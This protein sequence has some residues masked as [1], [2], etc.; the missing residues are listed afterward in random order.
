MRHF[1][2]PILMIFILVLSSGVSAAPTLISFPY[3]NQTMPEINTRSGDP[4]TLDI[5]DFVSGISPDDVK[6]ITYA[7]KDGVAVIFQ[8]A[9]DPLKIAVMFMKKISGR[10]ILPVKFMFSDDKESMLYLVVNVYERNEVIFKY[11]AEKKPESL[12]VAGSFNGWNAGKNSMEDPDNDGCYTA[13]I[14]IEP[15]IHTYKFVVDGKWI[16]DPE[17]PQKKD[18]G[19]QGF[20]SVIDLGKAKSNETVPYFIPFDIKHDKKNMLVDYIFYYYDE[21]KKQPLDFKSIQ[22]LIGNSILI[23]NYSREGKKISITIPEGELKGSCLRVFAKTEKGI[24]VH[25]GYVYEM[26]ESG[27]KK[28]FDWRDAIIYFTF[29]DRFYDGNPKNGRP[30]KDS[31]LADRANW[32][33]G[34]FAGIESK[35]KE[36][37]FNKL[38]INAIWLSPVNQ[39][40]KGAWKESIPPYRWFTGYHGYWPVEAR[41]TDTRLGSIEELKNL[42]K[43][44]HDHDIKIILDFVSNHVHKNHPYVKEHPEWFGTLDLPGGKKNIRL[45]DEYPFTTWFDTFLPSFN[46]PGSQEAQKQVISDAIWWLKTTDADGFRH[47]ATKHIPHDFWKKLCRKIRKEIEIPETRS[48]YQVGETISDRET[49]MEFVGPGLL[50]GQFDY[51]LMWTLRDAFGKGTIGVDELYKAAHKSDEDYGPMAIMSPFVSSHD[52]PRFIAFCDGD[53][54]DSEINDEKEVGWKKKLKVDKKISYDKLFM[55]M[56]FVMTRPGAPMVYYGDEIGMTGAGDPDNRR[57]MRFGKS[58][59][60]QEKKM[61]TRVSNLFK[62]RRKHPALSR[63]KG[64]SLIME[65]DRIAFIRSSFNDKILCVFNRSEKAYSTKVALPEVFRNYKKAKPLLG[66]NKLKIKEGIAEIKIPPYTAEF[67]E[68]K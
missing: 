65:K 24:D 46:Y 45:F 2:I 54:P 20:N 27:R 53:L 51:P 6:S 42:V 22:A 49:I 5:R 11:K 44:A 58:I 17:N 10:R 9:K 50:T 64:I 28:A 13:S 4:L 25:E 36:G 3:H 59:N 23:K 67:Y 35:I 62:V 56:A 21:S 18:D 39:N 37:Y 33:G 40:A 66:K 52:F 12:F 47:D 38:G 14:N 31:H 1:F 16:P 26:P 48:I 61:M 34:D 30:V 29:N 63:G 19:H 32:H 41:K 43:T 7:G 57:M 55:A 15:G 8:D 68:L 60:A